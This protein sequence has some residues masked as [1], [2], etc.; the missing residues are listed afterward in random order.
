MSATS[1]KIR[2]N[3]DIVN[4]RF[5]YSKTD[6]VSDIKYADLDIDKFVFLN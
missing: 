4:I 2:L 3:I 6:R 5:E 1:D